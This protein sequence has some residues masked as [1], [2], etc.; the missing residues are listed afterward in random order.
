VPTE[1]DA[2][3]SCERVHRENVAIRIDS[4]GYGSSSLGSGR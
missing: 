3:K 4:C 1:P 2:S